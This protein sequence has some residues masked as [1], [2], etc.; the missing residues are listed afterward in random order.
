M[1]FQLKT[2]IPKK[3]LPISAN[4]PAEK[5]KKRVGNI[6]W[7]N[8]EEEK[9]TMLVQKYGKKWLI[10]SQHYEGKSSYNCFYHYWKNVSPRFQQWSKDE[11]K[12]MIQ[13]LKENN[14][15]RS[16][17]VYMNKKPKECYERFNILKAKLLTKTISWKIEDEFKLLL[18]VEKIGKCWDK[19]K[20]CFSG[21]K[22]NSISKKFY[23]ILKN[24]AQKHSTNQQHHYRLQ[25]IMKYLPLVVEEFRRKILSTTEGL[26][27][28]NEIIT[29][30]N[31]LILENKLTNDIFEIRIIKSANCVSSR[32]E[33]LK[34]IIKNKLSEKLIKKL[35]KEIPKLPLEISSQSSSP[36]QNLNSIIHK[37]QSLK[38]V[39]HNVNYVI[40]F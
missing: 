12:K 5:F 17:G 11:D 29:Q 26:K 8:E 15:W 35:E 6:S 20:I 24:F 38:N 16:C 40:K 39:L 10:I 13:F 2:D 31:T 9:L 37:I 1:N 18:L 22:K 36:L 33:M 25:S 27:N 34:A 28:M 4:I 14:S 21:K 32:K 19:I 3:A 7:T 23:A 30:I